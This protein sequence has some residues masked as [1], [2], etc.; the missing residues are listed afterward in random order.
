MSC[1]A[2]HGKSHRHH[3]SLIIFGQYKNACAW[4][5]ASFSPDSRFV[6]AGSSSGTMCVWNVDTGKLEAAAETGH[7]K[8]V[9]CSSWN[10][11]GMQLASGDA[12]GVVCFWE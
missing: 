3:H 10:R 2:L 4:N 11:S 9:S 8:T 1:H 6:V 12:E 7:T 5:R